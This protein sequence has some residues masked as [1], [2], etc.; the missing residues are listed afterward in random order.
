MPLEQAPTIWH[1]VKTGGG[2]VDF[3]TQ[4]FAHKLNS[5]Y[6][7]YLEKSLKNNPVRA[8]HPLYPKLLAR[9]LLMAAEYGFPQLTNQVTRHQ[10]KGWK[11]DM[12]SAVHIL[13]LGVSL[14]HWNMDAIQSKLKILESW[15]GQTNSFLHDHVSELFAAWVLPGHPFPDAKTFLSKPRQY[16]ANR[17]WS[18]LPV[19]IPD[20]EF[21]DRVR[22]IPL[23]GTNADR[24]TKNEFADTILPIA[25]EVFFPNE[26]YECVEDLF[27]NDPATWTG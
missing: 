23:T 9:S 16:L 21:L 1:E 17:L 6:I 19:F 7:Y 4:N 27:L 11:R 26:K 14:A 22:N 15:E 18:N 3:V 2:L 24:M 12:F 20:I 13:A 8:T 5:E 25:T 10:R